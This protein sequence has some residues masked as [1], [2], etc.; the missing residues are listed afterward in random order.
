M[1]LTRLED[2]QEIL[3][4]NN[5][6]AKKKFG[7]NFLLNRNIID[8]ACNEANV[9]NNDTIIEIG[10]GLGVLT[11]ELCSRAKEVIACEIDTD[12]IPVLE[13]TTK[14]F[15]NLTILQQN[16]L[17]YE[18]EIQNYK[19]VANIPY[20]IT[21]HLLRHFLEEIQYKPTILVLMVQKEVAE[22]I[23]ATQGNLNLLGLGVQVFGKATYITTVAR[24]DFHPVPEVDSALVKIEVFDTPKIEN[25]K[26]FF[27]LVNYCF[28]KKRK[29]LR[30]SLKGYAKI[31]I[32]DIEN[33]MNL[34][35]RPQELSIEDW[36]TILNHMK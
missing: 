33:Y 5:L 35:K 11:Q 32:E 2:I 17:T 9:S 27:H 8:I 12:I 15:K 18:P 7:Q 1:D 26:Q 4:N 24:N 30:T 6:W 19:V 34:D 29:K 25:N 13:E 14:A 31:N 28:Q 20:Y 3:K 21:G 16:A 36:Q 23:T 22:K 10:P